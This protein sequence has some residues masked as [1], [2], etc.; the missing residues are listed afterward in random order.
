MRLLNTGEISVKQ[1]AT[2]IIPGRYLER[3]GDDRQWVALLLLLITTSD[4]MEKEDM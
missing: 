3:G 2:Y 1:Q 4:L